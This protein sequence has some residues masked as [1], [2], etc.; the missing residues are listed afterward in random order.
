MDNKELD[1][2]VYTKKIYPLDY[3]PSLIKAV[4]TLSNPNYEVEFFG[5]SVFKSLYLAGD[6]DLRQN[7]PLNKIYSSM[8][9]ILKKIKDENYILGDIK[10]G[11]D[12]RFELLKDALGYVKYGRVTN[13]KP[14]LIRQIAQNYNLKI[15]ILQAHL[16]V[17]SSAPMGIMLCKIT[18]DEE[19]LEQAFRFLNS[20]HISTE[21]IGYVSGNFNSIA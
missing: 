7:L 17:V 16:D 6:V 20:I 12:P 10:A 2:F 13:Y 9:S 5:S 21:V 11:L 19:K 3:P 8:V 4:K 15:N 18:G 14:S 1:K